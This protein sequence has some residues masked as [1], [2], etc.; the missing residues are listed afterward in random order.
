MSISL[1]PPSRFQLHHT[2]LSFHDQVTKTLTKTQV[3]IKAEVAASNTQAR[4][5]SQ[6]V[7]RLSRMVEDCATPSPDKEVPLGKERR[8]MIDHILKRNL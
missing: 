2:E 5:L 3:R 1:A 6:A 8:N 7:Q 4:Q